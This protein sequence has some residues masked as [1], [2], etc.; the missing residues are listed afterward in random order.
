[1]RA[2]GQNLKTDFVYDADFEMNFDNR[3]FYKSAF[4]ESPYRSF[5]P[6]QR[7]PL[8]RMSAGCQSGFQSW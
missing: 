4:Y 3:E 6:F 8:F 2:D 5:L 7:L 1:M